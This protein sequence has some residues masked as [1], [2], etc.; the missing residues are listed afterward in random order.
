MTTRITRAPRQTPQTYDSVVVMWSITDET[1][2]E[3]IDK[4]FTYV[5]ST[6][7]ASDLHC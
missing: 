1:L 6:N 4:E 7:L 2:Q 5:Y 3:N